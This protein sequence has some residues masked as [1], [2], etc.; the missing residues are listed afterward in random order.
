LTSASIGAAGDGTFDFV[1]DP[2]TGNVSCVYDGDIRIAAATPLQRLRLISASGQLL[3]NNLDVSG[4]DITLRSGT[5]LDGGTPASIPDGYNLGP[6]LP[7]GLTATQLTTDLTLFWQV[8][9]GG[10][11]M[12]SGDIIVKQ[13]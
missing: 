6:V 7:T 13:P 4:F 12:K 9:N 10:L 5:M 8:K 11:R 1:Y 3:G 2:T